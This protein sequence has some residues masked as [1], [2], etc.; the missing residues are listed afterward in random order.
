MSAVITFVQVRETGFQQDTFVPIAGVDNRS[1]DSQHAAF[2]AFPLPT[3]EFSPGLLALH[4]DHSRPLAAVAQIGGD[5]FPLLK[6]RH[7][8]RLSPWV[9]E[10]G[11]T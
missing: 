4:E 3:A 1:S 11:A 2:F 5:V 8:R 7:K 10:N 9:N 6:I